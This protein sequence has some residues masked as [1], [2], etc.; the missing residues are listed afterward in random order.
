ME[1]ALLDPVKELQYIKKLMEEERKI[2][3]TEA[4]ILSL[5]FYELLKELGIV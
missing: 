5:W 2:S 3:R 4:I 1:E